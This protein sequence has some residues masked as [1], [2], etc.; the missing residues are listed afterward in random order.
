MAQLMVPLVES[1]TY[2][3]VFDKAVTAPDLKRVSQSRTTPNELVLE[4][5]QPMTW[6]DTMASQFR[7]DGQPG[8]VVSGVVSGSQLRLRTMG[9]KPVSEITWIVDRSWDP[10]ALVYGTNGIAALTFSEVSVD[11]VE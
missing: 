4:F 3:R 11:Q 1:R 10:G 8:R 6:K 7:L 5:D 9:E 2:G